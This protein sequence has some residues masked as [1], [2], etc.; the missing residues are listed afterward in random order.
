M[1][2]MLPD[3]AVRQKMR[4]DGFSD[5]VIEAVLAGAPVD[6]SSLSLSSNND[7]PKS[8]LAGLGE[9][10]LKSAAAATEVKPQKRMS[11]LDEI[12]S[13][14]KLKAVKEDDSRMK[15]TNTNSGAGGLLDKLAVEMFKRRV[16]MLQDSDSD[17]DASGFSDS[18]SDDD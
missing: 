11:M 9:V 15:P 1:K 6:L 12:Q 3:G 14:I 4:V 10:K 17:S 16:N 13:G 5:N 8:P 2:D 18:D 7:T